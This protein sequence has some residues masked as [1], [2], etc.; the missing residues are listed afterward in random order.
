[1]GYLK[2]VESLAH[3]SSQKSP[4]TPLFQRGVKGA[5]EKN[6][7]LK[8]GSCEKIMKKILAIVI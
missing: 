4:L 3:R 7:P 2:F 6:P 8:K 1:V 5:K